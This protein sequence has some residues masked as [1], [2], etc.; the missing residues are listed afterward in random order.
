MKP[1]IN[2]AVSRR[3]PQII[4][5]RVELLELRPTVWRKLLVPS[6]ITLA[7]L[8]QLLQV[9]MG[10]TNS[11]LHQFKIGA[12]CYGFPDE[13][14]PERSP[15]DDRK[16]ILAD[17]LSD[18][19]T[20]FHYEYDFGDGWEHA[21]RIERFRALDEVRHYPLCVAGANACPPEDVGGTHG[22]LEFLQAITDPTHEEHDNYLAWCG[23]LFDPAAFDV[24]A[25]NASLR[26]IKIPSAR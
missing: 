7:K 24:N 10:W 3:P 14:W 22:Y 20:G 23:G 6:W 1:S 8:H 11:H 12:V 15:R 9:A 13:D 17:S 21:I 16:A 19:L 4:E 2:S 18:E 25:V 26:R 5:L